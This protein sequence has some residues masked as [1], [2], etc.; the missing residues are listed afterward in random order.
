MRNVILNKGREGNLGF[1]LP[2]KASGIHI[3]RRTTL[4]LKKMFVKEER[5]G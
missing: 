2:E 1:M 5:H 3:E 4:P